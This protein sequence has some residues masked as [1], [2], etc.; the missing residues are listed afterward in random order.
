MTSVNKIKKEAIM[1]KKDF[2]SPEIQLIHMSQE[3]IL[4]TSG[5]QT[6]SDGD[7]FIVDDGYDL[8]GIFVK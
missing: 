2:V 7:D 6:Y 4:S 8:G 3:D 5:N 1:A